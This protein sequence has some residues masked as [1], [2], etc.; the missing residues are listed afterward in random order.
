MWLENWRASI[1]VPPQRWTLD[2]AAVHDHPAAVR[3][4]R[5]AR[6]AP[7]TSRPSST[8]RAR[9][10][11]M[12]SAVAGLVPEVAVDRHQRGL[13]AS[14]GP[15]RLAKLKLRWMIPPIAR[16]TGYLDPQWGVTRATLDPPKADLGLRAPDP[17]RMRQ[18]GVQAGRAS[19]TAPACPTL[20][21][22]E[23]LND[24]THEWLS[25]EFADVPLT[26]FEQI[27]AWVERGPPGGRRTGTRSCRRT[28]V[29]RRRRR[30][31]RASRSSPAR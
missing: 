9:R 11:F 27:L 30:R 23:N 2:Q 15:N 28:F 22:H 16:V 19:P 21:R 13:A 4:V 29:E 7:T 5:R 24:E 8:A 6:R 26:F 1:D 18:H 25:D 14:G 17:P 12:M 10:S 20:W 31:T 3:T